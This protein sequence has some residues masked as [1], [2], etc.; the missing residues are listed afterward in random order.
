MIGLSTMLSNVFN[1]GDLDS[2]WEISYLNFLIKL[3]VS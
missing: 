2:V 3:K 1:L